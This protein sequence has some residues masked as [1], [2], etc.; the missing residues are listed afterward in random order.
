MYIS[1]DQLQII[2]SAI[3]SCAKNYDGLNVIVAVVS[4]LV[5][6]VAVC[7]SIHTAKKQNK[8]A[9]YEKRLGCYL[10]FVELKSFANFIEK[11][12]NLL[13]GKIED[14]SNDNS[15]ILQLQSKYM[16]IHSLFSNK[17][18]RQYR[19]DPVQKGIYIGD[20][21]EKDKITLISMEFL[22]KSTNKI[23]VSPVRESLAILIGQLFRSASAIEI[24]SIRQAAKDFT[25]KFYALETVESE[26][27]A[28]L[29]LEK[30]RGKE[31][32]KT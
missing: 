31:N 30:K 27:E 12:E 15:K 11:E 5:S 17:E 1:E 25:A 21:L 3:E 8:I 13:T 19:F 26:F 24:D 16:D 23:N 20:C 18:F 9:L 28:L 2:T 29:R 14:R 7:I 4:A 32:A 22:L 10:Q 6:F